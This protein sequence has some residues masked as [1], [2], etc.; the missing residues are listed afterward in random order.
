MIFDVR[1]SLKIIRKFFFRISYI[2]RK[3]FIDS[4]CSFEVCPLNNTFEGNLDF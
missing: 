2:A 1:A 4:Q 3:N